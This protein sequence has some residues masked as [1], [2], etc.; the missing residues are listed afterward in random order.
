MTLA[1]TV[2]SLCFISAAWSSLGGPTTTP[3]GPKPCAG[4][5]EHLGGI[6]QRL[7]RDAADVE[8]SAA[9]RLALFDH[10]DLHAELG[11]ADRADVAGGAGADHDD[12]MSHGKF[13]RFRTARW[14]SVSEG[15]RAYRRRAAKSPA[16]AIRTRREPANR[17]TPVRTPDDRD[18]PETVRVRRA[19]DDDRAGHRRC[20]QRSRASR[21][22]R[23]HDASRSSRGRAA[24]NGGNSPRNWRSARVPADRRSPLVERVQMVSST[25]ANSIRIS[26]P[27][28]AP[29]SQD[30]HCARTCDDPENELSSRQTTSLMISPIAATCGGASEV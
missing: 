21:P 12:I 4:L 11:R 17:Q 5:L 3:S 14:R 18:D 20:A 26:A 1:A 9:E 15:A 25:D 7:R 19:A 10:G 28:P 16:P 8:A 29:N 13:F 24:T 23:Q 2:S 30:L 27:K 6:E 22:S